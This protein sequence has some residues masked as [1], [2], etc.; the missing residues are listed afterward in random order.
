M[1]TCQYFRKLKTLE[2]FRTHLVFTVFPPLAG[3][4]N[5]MVY[6][7]DTGSSRWLIQIHSWQK[8]GVSVHFPELGKC[9]LT[10]FLLES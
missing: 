9:T 8:N 10:P 4:Y 2:F 1:V 5:L 3:L 6:T 7:K